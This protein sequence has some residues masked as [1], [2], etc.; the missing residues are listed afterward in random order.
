[1]SQEFIILISIIC[2]L[3]VL[4]LV[5]FIFIWLKFKKNASPTEIFSNRTLRSKE[6]QVE[7]RIKELDD[8][9]E[10][11]KQSKEVYETKLQALYNK[12]EN[13]L[14]EEVFSL[15]KNKEKK[16][17]EASL[18][19]LKENAN[20]EA[21][22]ILV[23]CMESIAE[24]LIQERATTSISIQED[25]LKGRIIGKEGR[26][27]RAFEIVTGTDLIVEKD[28][29]FITISSHNPIRREIAKLLL[30]ELIKTKTIDPTKIETT[31]GEV[32]KKFEEHL[33][34]VGKELVEGKLEIFDLNPQI[35]PYL[36]RL[37]FR[38]SYGQ[39]ALN[40]S[41]ECACLAGSMA[42][43]LKIDKKL[44]IECAL[45][46]D[47]GKSMDQEVNTN[48]IDVGKKIALELN[49]GS[50]IVNAIESHHGNVLCSSIYAEIAKL[51]DT[52]SAARP[53]ARI[54]SFEEY[55]TR[56]QELEN[57]VN[58]FPEVK[59]SCVVKSGRHLRVMINP[60]LVSDNDLYEIGSKIKDK[61]ETNNIVKGYN[62]K[63]TL[64]KE[65]KYEF[66]TESQLDV[67]QD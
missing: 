31:Y 28:S 13:E 44:A 14:K 1:M 22:N 12:P 65:F 49:L 58:Q 23:H 32:N 24:P 55:F 51:A 50:E 54:N 38:T 16:N 8:S 26:N 5:G 34:E 7:K 35:Y 33:A 52:I 59:N 10:A 36:G 43:Q 6:R 64:I 61:I 53:G 15:I 42:E 48:H 11:Y 60:Y 56:V 29:D 20:L 41:Y 17:I 18:I 3:F 27:K 57:I 62:I 19:E 25:Q 63:V 9:I 46:H 4:I 30:E 21:A 37:K 40:H 67:V 39:N 2:L 45:L 66:E 47:I